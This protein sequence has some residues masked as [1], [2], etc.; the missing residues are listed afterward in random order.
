MGKAKEKNLLDRFIEWREKHISQRQFIL[1]LSFV[2]GVISSLAAFVLKHFIE[3]IQHRLT[4]GFESDSFNWLYLIY[5]VVG[6]FITGL[7]IRNVVRDDISHGVTKVL[8]SISRR[9][10]RIKRHNMWSSLIASGITIGF[11]GSV[12]A[13]SP[14]VFTGSAIGSNLASF[15]KMDQKVM[16]L[17]IG[18]GAAGAVSG[19]FKA[20]IA[21]L[22]FTL[23]VLM[24]DLTMSSLLPLLISSVTAVTLSYLLSGTDAMFH[25]QLEDAFS[26]SR[27]PYVMLLGIMCGLISLYF[28]HVTAGVEKYFRRFQ[29]PY[30]RLAIGGSV[31]SILIFLFPP[32]YGEGYNMIN[33]L[34]N[35]SSADV[36]LNNS[37][38]YGHANLLFL[39]MA[40]IILFK[41]F[42]STVTN[43]GG[44]CG[45][46]F[47]PSLFLGCISGYLF[48]GLCNMF[49]LGEVL[50]DKNF[51]LFGMAALMSGV[52]HAP[53]TGVFLIAELTGGY[54]LFLPLMIVS[55]C[56]Y[57]TVRLFDDN[58]IYA[59][60]LAQRGELITHHK[61][62]AVLTILKVE[63]VIEKNFMRVDPDMDLG[64]LT[65][66]VAKTKRNIFPVVNAADRLVGIVF[67]DD[68]RHMM[69]RQELYHR[70]TVA[71]LMRSVPV[72]LSIEEPMEAVMRKFEETNAWN[73]PVEDTAGNYIGFI[74]K[75]AIF[76]AYRKTL[77]DFTSD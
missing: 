10:G 75:S 3:F 2:V 29:N 70:F 9:Q 36:I 33:H 13:E 25:F 8:Y 60:R 28:T 67:L 63:D 41:V 51:A 6:I 64:A 16:M 74:S 77:L 22:V 11:G 47:A 71:K 26:V 23:E 5:P 19:I 37:L 40:L 12:G 35:G 76:T 24:L 57:L 30:A 68:I 65:S 18:C 43:C 46:I 73:L 15:F 45:G 4:G 48:A 58:N 42:A 17:L 31:L 55:V 50:P 52:F 32:L 7:F 72:R 49:G 53:L 66:V 38:F 34:I 54:D 62:Q 69:F 39:Y 21:G 44:G 1:L 14:I 27:V 59:I 61:D 56:S 20:P